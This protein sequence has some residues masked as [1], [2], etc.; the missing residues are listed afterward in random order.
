LNVTK[1]SG[2]NKTIN[3]RIIN[4]ENMRHTNNN[5]FPTSV[6]KLPNEK[7]KEQYIIKA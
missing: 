7:P 3:K 5:P 2:C 6:I 4:Y 1:D